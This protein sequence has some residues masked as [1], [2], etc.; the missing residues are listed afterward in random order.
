MKKNFQ[1]LLVAATLLSTIS[2]TSCLKTKISEPPNAIDVEA[3]VPTDA[4]YITIGALKA[5]TTGTLIIKDSVYITGFV[6]ANDK[7]GNFYKQIMLQDSTGGIPLLL[8]K[9]GLSGEYPVGRKVHVKCK[10]LT[11][12]PYGRFMQLGYAVDATNSLAGIPSALIGSFVIKS[13]MDPDGAKP[14]VVTLSQ[15]SNPDNPIANKLLGKLLEIRDVEFIGTD[16]QQPYAQPSTVSS[17]TNRMIEDCGGNTVTM[18][19]SGFAQFQPEITPSG[20][21]TLLAVYTRYNTT[22]QI[23]IRNTE[24]VKFTGSRCGSNASLLSIQALKDSFAA[25][26]TVLVNEY[27]IKGIVI[28][29]K[30]NS[31]IQS[32]NLVLQDGAAGIV[33]R[34]Q[35]G[36]TFPYLMGDEIEVN[37]TGGTLSEYQKTLQ[38]SANT[39]KTLKLGTGTITPAVKTIAEITANM[40]ALESTL[41]RVSNVTFPVGTYGGS[42]PV[43]DGT[44]TMTLFTYNTSTV[45]SFQGDLMP[46]TPKTLTAI[47]G[48][49]GTTN[50]LSMRNTAD[51]Q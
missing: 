18:R 27:K 48:Q 29:D 11:M 37:I 49:Y 24:D 8:E 22:P 38:I 50:Q 10:G 30:I 39:S 14:T 47:V 17:A 28:S 7:G 19:V 21:G 46:T 40:D 25:G 2:I 12:S 32:S 13:K 35:S 34:F 43:T 31:N 44:G 26:K 51:V 15:I 36:A 6:V 33:V 23:M 5:K 4:K 9:N 20:K 16:I 45:A 41:V 3:A 42:K 1:I